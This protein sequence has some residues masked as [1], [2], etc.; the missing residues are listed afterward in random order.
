[1]ECADGKCELCPMHILGQYTNLVVLSKYPQVLALIQI[2]LNSSLVSL[3]DYWPQGPIL[4][5][6]R[7]KIM[8]KLVRKD[9]HSQIVV[10]SP[11]MH[12]FVITTLQIWVTPTHTCQEKKNTDT[13]SNIRCVIKGIKRPIFTFGTPMWDFRS[14][15]LIW[16]GFAFMDGMDRKS[17]NVI[18]QDS[19]GWKKAMQ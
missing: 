3:C 4:G 7:I 6:H 9:I 12:K 13:P 14:A 19:C 17:L 16:R 15:P 8:P 11:Q 5:N 18:V 1:M 10:T 2:C